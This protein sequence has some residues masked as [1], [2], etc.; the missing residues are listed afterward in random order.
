MFGR[1]RKLHVAVLGS[2]PAGL[3][4]AWGAEQLGHEV[5][6]FSQGQKST[7]YGAQYL[8]AEIPGLDCGRMETIHYY[9]KGEPDGYR[10]KVYGDEYEGPVSP[11]SLAGFHNCWDIR[12]AYDSAWER[13]SD[14][15]WPAQIT[16]KWLANWTPDADRI[17]WSIPLQAQCWQ[18]GAH[19]FSATEVW[20]QGDAP[21]LGRYCSVT[22]EPFTV[23][24]NGEDSP[25]W[26]R[27]SNVYGH[28]TA[29]W[30][31]NPKPP[32][33]GLA[34]VVKPISNACDCWLK[35]G[36]APV[37]RVGRYGRWE[38]GQLSHDAYFQ[39]RA[40]LR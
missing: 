18:L 21:D 15:I 26:Y 6:I 28:R 14:R 27:A 5:S 11:V 39:A 34:R 35:I 8:H 12:R 38:K 2:G 36:D 9:L 40:W 4:A 3:F 22:V 20:A 30:P 23:V 16:P 37:L 24:T 7:M 13:Y 10:R 1:K 32:V 31:L 25:R 33:S 17:I 19:R 29:E